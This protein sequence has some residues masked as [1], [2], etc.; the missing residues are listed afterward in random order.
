M[1]I[2]NTMLI[3][4]LR[5][6]FNV[7]L[8]IVAI[9]L[10]GCFIPYI[11]SQFNGPLL[12]IAIALA[13][14]LFKQRGAFICISI[15]AIAMA[16]T[17]TIHSSGIFWPSSLL[18]GFVTGTIALMI[19]SFFICY[20]RYLLEMSELSRIEMMQAIKEKQS[21]DSAYKQQQHLNQLK[22]RFIVNISHELCT[23]VQSA[24]GHIELLQNFDE[25]LD[26]VT[27]K[28]SLNYALHACYDLQMIV[29]NTLDYVGISTGEQIPKTE[30]VLVT[31]IAQ[32]VL[33]LLE[34]KQLQTATLHIDIPDNLMITADPQ[35][36]RQILRNLLT[37]ALKYR[38][39]PSSILIKADTIAATDQTEQS[40]A[41]VCISVQDN[42]PGIP[43][44]EIAFIFER[45]VRLQRDLGGPVRGT[46]LGLAI[47]KELVEAMGGQIWVQSSGILGEGCC[48]S[49]I[50]PMSSSS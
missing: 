15:T 27:R 29:N 44:G 6:S 35:H 18:M 28:E 38:L 39:D 32:D 1:R 48:F 50:L 13:A 26:S 16:V 23:P 9:G 42:G 41:Q 30:N 19:E 34:P 45:F 40:H 3:G 22:D 47:C 33:S 4:L 17:I 8:T 49:F 2:L 24:L 14:W 37:N 46:G 43:P 20:L 7:R 21:I 12:A 10:V 36:T 31:Q 11:F 5:L 25:Q